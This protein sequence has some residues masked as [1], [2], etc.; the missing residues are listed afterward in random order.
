LCGAFEL[1][2]GGFV[3]RHF[4]SCAIIWGF[5]VGL[6]AEEEEVSDLMLTFICATPPSMCSARQAKITTELI[7][8]ISGAESIKNAAVEQ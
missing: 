4:L 5:V 2:Q 8:I 1:G 6:E 3:L 7:E